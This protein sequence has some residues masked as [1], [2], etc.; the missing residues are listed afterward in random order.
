[1]VVFWVNAIDIITILISIVLCF[2]NLRRLNQSVRYIIY[3]VFVFIYVVPLILDYI[4]G[5]PNYLVWYNAETRYGGFINS[6]NDPKVRVLYDI[7]L[8]ISQFGIV[9]IGEKIKVTFG[10]TV[11]IPY[12]KKDVKTEI[13]FD[14]IL[15][16]KHI[17][18]CIIPAMIPPLLCLVNGYPYIM[19]KWGWRDL[20]MF[21]S[22]ALS[23]YYSTIERMTY[24]SI[25]L[26]LCI[27]MSKGI[28]NKSRYIV[29]FYKVVAAVLLMANACIESKRSIMFFTI[30]MVLVIKIYG[31]G[32]KFKLGRY[33]MICAIGVIGV[34]AYSI[35]VKTA[36]RGYSSFIE[37]YTNLRVDMFRD[38]TVKLVIKSLIDSNTQKLLDF[39]FQSYLT[40]IGFLFPLDFIIGWLG[41]RIPK[42]GFNTYLTA[43]LIGG[44]IDSGARWMTTSM[45]DEIIAN[46]G[47]WGFII[48]PLLLIYLIRKIDNMEGISQVLWIGGIVLMMMYSLNY[49]IYYLE[50]AFFIHLILKH[51]GKNIIDREDL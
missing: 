45:G 5:L 42:I 11:L 37:V 28:K 8:L 34:L 47:F 6:Y 48:F 22:V 30:I 36:M 32:K 33:I 1:M 14:G 23:P 24:I 46:F 25:V 39:P 21:S 27:I 7:F 31:W 18:M 17:F 10:N 49:I 40:Q 19:V 15:S 3:Y 13:Y 41:I 12:S 4:V 2:R 20:Q 9:Y 16:Q 38:D 26:M 51:R 50:F 35:Y 44:S 29:C 43:A